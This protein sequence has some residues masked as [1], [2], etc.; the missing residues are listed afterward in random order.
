MSTPKEQK[1]H[2]RIAL[3][4][5][6][7]K[8]IAK[9]YDILVDK[10]LFIKEI[11]ESND[12]SILITY[13]R[14]WGKTLNL[15]ML[16]TFLESESE[17]C[18]NKALFQQEIETFNNISQK[19]NWKQYINPK[20]LFTKLFSSQKNTLMSKI[21]VFLNYSVIEIYLLAVI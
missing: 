14:R 7:F 6:D 17:E 21:R 11:I 9:E 13:P 15:N 19:T 5:D 3:G 12:K 1:K 8:E 10:T 4:T 18:N 2:L 20:T 16:K